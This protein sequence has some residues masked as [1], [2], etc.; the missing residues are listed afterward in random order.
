M[1]HTHYSIKRLIYQ[2]K[3]DTIH[4]VI[5]RKKGRI[6]LTGK[7]HCISNIATISLIH[8]ATVSIC[9]SETNVLAPYI[10]DITYKLTHHN[11]FPTW[12]IYV[13]ATCLFLI[14]TYL[15]D[16]DSKS[17][18]IGKLFYIPVEHR[19]WTHAIWFPLIWGIVFWFLFPPL[20]WVSI[21]YFLH[22][23]W[24]SLSVGG[25]CFCYPFTNYRTFRGGAKVKK[26]HYL[27]LYRV[28]S[29]SETVLL[30]CL[31]TTTIVLYG[32]VYIPKLFMFRLRLMM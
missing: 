1:E 7:H 11:D 24:D 10:S 4:L 22:L 15:P 21:G 23:F 8:L 12:F 6:C 20:V 30:A 19:T 18:T 3:C 32:V 27:K 16:C 29:V 9:E 5:I 31:I 14:G 2:G 26:H 13:I 17:S 28:G 25:V